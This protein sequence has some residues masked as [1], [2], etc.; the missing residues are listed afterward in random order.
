MNRVGEVR[1]M[2]DMAIIQEDGA[3]CRGDVTTQRD[4]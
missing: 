4:M 2:K 1:A 3:M